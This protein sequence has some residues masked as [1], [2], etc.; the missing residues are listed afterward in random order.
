MSV[1]IDGSKLNDD[2][3]K[4]LVEA[5]TVVPKD[6]NEGKRHFGPKRPTKELIPVAMYELLDDNK[7]LRIPYRAGCGLKQE[8]MNYDKPHI[9]FVVNGVPEFSVSFRENQKPIMEEAWKQ[10]KSYSTTTLG[11]PP[12][13]GKCLDPDTFVRL[14]NGS[15]KQAKNMLVGDLLFNDSGDPTTI[16]SVCK[17]VQEMATIIPYKGKSFKCNMDH[18]LTLINEEDVID[19]SVID[20]INQSPGFQQNYKLYHASVEYRKTDVLDP[21][22]YGFYTK[23]GVLSREYVINTSEIRLKVLAGYIDSRGEIRGNTVYVERSASIEEIAL[24]LGFMAYYCEKKLAIEGMLGLIPSLDD[25][26]NTINATHQ[27]FHV[28]R[29]SKGDYAG[30]T[31]DGNGRFLLSDYTVTHNTIMG[32]ALSYLAGY[33]TLV[34]CNRKSIAE[35]WRKTFL[36]CYPGYN[37]WIWVV[38]EDP[39][40]TFITPFIICLDTRYQKIPKNF[41]QA[42]GTLIVDEAHLFCTPK[43]VPCLFYV[44]PRVIII[45]TATLKRED[46]MHVM[47]QSIAGTHGVFTISNAPYVVK[48]VLTQIPI[49]VEKNKFGNDYTDMCNKMAHCRAR[50]ELICDIVATNLHRKYIILTRRADH[51]VILKEMFEEMGIASGTLY[52]NKNRYNDSTVLIGTMPKI[53]TGFDEENACED[54]RGDKS[55]VLILANS[56]KQYQ[57]FEQYRGRVMRCKSPIV[58]WIQ[59]PVSTI[60]NHFLGLRSWIEET[61]GSIEK[62]RYVKGEF[63]LPLENMSPDVQPLPAIVTSLPID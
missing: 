57:S 53:G 60:N 23:K 20:Y 47:I 54:F 43:K 32:A 40:P 34:L 31:L 9:K 25:L 29:S 16:T 49:D 26:P 61:N 42:V 62:M 2:D 12:G 28:V 8:M 11:V 52:G 33:N 1:E 24:S 6:P 41:A 50:N 39:E 30:F 19:I 48:R 55:N 7:T 45:E 18:M 35:Q 21:Y 36:K 10:I 56:V 46:G 44:Q 63:K 27:H 14:Y 17:G 3:V 59:D 13:T 5:L 4:N 22:Q 15:I 38:G 37:S 58:I 51:V